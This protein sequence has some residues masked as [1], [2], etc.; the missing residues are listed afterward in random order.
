L[1]QGTI[2]FIRLP[3]SEGKKYGPKYKYPGRR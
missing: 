3:L 1:E 2:V